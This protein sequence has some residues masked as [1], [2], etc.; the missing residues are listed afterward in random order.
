[1]KILVSACLLGLSCRYDGCS[2]ENPAAVAL[3]GRHTLIPFCPEVYGGLATPREPSE[4]RDGRVVTRSG[5]EVTSQF[6]RG[7]REAL[8]IAQL[9]GC[10]CALLQD[11]SPSCGVGLIHDG[12]FTGGLTEGDGLT[13][14]LLRAHGVR[15]IPASR[16][17]ELTA[18]PCPKRCRRHNDC[19]ACRAHHAGRRHPP[20]CER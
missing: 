17:A 16:L 1:M 19:D 10:A 14:A 15:V 2:K 6:E 4:I 12:T 3:A 18:C 8:R 7:A 20:Y 9:L 11:R 5:A 13:A